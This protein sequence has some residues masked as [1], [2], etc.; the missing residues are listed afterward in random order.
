MGFMRLRKRGIEAQLR[1]DRPE[2]P[3]ALVEDIASRVVPARQRSTTGSRLS[4]AASVAVLIVGSFASFG[5]IGYAASVTKET[6]HTVKQIAVHHHI[7][8]HRTSA[9]SQYNTPPNNVGAA[10]TVQP[11]S[12]VLGVST[13]P[14]PVQAQGTLPFTGISLGVTVAISLLLM[15]LGLMLRRRASGSA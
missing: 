4:F 15:G 3:A 2:A 1:R 8:A 7:T 5:G 11:K 12:Q 13:A 6:A 9:A 14:A 10:P